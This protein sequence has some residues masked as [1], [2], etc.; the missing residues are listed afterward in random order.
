MHRLR[1]IVAQRVI[2]ALQLWE[3]DFICVS[4]GRYLSLST[5]NR[6]MSMREGIET[7]NR[8]APKFKGCWEQ[9][10]IFFIL[11]LSAGPKYVRSS[12]IAAQL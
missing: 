4:N 2:F 12:V 11:S 9:Y 8:E 10:G 7:Y 5:G 6:L 1:P 3:L